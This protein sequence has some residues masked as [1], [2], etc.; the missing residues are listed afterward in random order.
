MFSSF[1]LSMTWLHT[2]FG[3]ALGYVLMVCFFFGALSVFDREIDRWAI[4]A[5]R[6]E[7]QPMPSFDKMLMPILSQLK[8]DEREFTDM[9]PRLVDLSKGPLPARESLQPDEYFVYTTHRDPVLSMGAGYLLPNPKDP[10]AHNHVH[11]FV[12]IDPRTGTPLPAERFHKVGSN[13][14]YPMHYSLH[15]HWKDLGYW[16]VGLAAL[17]ML[18]ALVSG[19]V[20]H[21][22]IFAEFFTFRPHKH[23]RRSTLD[24]HN[25]TGVV[26]LPF[27]FFFAFTGLVIFAGIYLPVSETTLKPLAKAHEVVEAA[28]TG[29]PHERAGVAASLASVDAMVAQAKLRVRCAAGRRVDAQRCNGAAIGG[30]NGHAA[31]VVRLVRCGDVGFSDTQRGARVAQPVCAG[32]A[33]GRAGLVVVAWRCGMKDGFKGGWRRSMSMRRPAVEASGQPSPLPALVVGRPTEFPLSVRYAFQG[34]FTLNERRK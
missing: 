21:R 1:R 28:R 4:P 20:M 19:V 18:A 26:G 29:L 10:Q 2:W 8:A 13:F 27:H 12:T 9:A 31:R 3:L 16:I 6:Y 24:L 15:L 11:G 25:L 22:K 7:P 14:F 30:A 34:L 32:C 33:D 23:T 5:T 17:V